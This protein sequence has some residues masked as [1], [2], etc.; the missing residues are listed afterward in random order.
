MNRLVLK[1]IV[2][3]LGLLLI[4]GISQA[5]ESEPENEVRNQRREMKEKHNAV[6]EQNRERF[7]AT[8]TEDQVAILE[9]Q[10]MTR[11]QRRRAFR[12]LLS[13]HQR[14]MLREHREVRKQQRNEFRNCVSEEQRRQRQQV[15]EREKTRTGQNERGE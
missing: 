8:L 13:D 2:A 11:N 15:R 7:R 3:A 4:S 10:E 1:L 5:Q 6:N 12:A 14:E 9:N